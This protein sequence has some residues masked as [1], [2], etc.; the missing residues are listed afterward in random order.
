MGVEHDI[1]ILCGEMTNDCVA[2]C[3]ELY[4]E[5]S[6]ECIGSG[7]ICPDCEPELD[8]WRRSGD[9]CI[10]YIPHTETVRIFYVTSADYAV[11]KE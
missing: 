8:K 5:E 7:M 4:F 2:G 10:Y 11:T 1:C 6:D 9:D 3:Y